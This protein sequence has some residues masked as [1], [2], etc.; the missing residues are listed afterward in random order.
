[1]KVSLN[2]LREYVEVPDDV[3]ALCELLTL[4]GVEVEGIETRGLTSDKV[5]VAEILSSEQHPNADR[6]SVCRVNDGGGEPRQIVCGAKNYR[7]GDKV[8]L[9]LPGAVLP[10]DFKIK[11]GKLRGVE[12]QGMMCSAKE[13]NL[14][15][16]A[17]G[18]LILP[19]SATVGTPVHELFAPDTVLDVEVTPNRPDLLSHVGMAREISALARR[20]LTVPTIDA[21]AGEANGGIEIRLRAGEDCPHY[22]A[23]RISG[24]QVKP[25]PEWMQRRLEAVGLRP[26]NNV[27]DVTNF[28]MLELGQPLHAF[29]AREI[30]RSIRVRHAT[31]G[32]N[33]LALDGRN[34]ALSPGHMVI[35]DDEKAL[36]IAGIMGGEHSG[37]TEKTTDVVLESAYFRP[38]N[39][40]R[41]SRELGLSSDSSYRFERGV[42]PAGVTAASLRAAKLIVE[43]GGGRIESFSEGGNAPADAVGVVALREGRCSE[44]AGT[45]IAEREVEAILSRL[46][47]TREGTGWRTPTYRPDLTREIDLVEEVV[48]VYGIENI[49]PRT[50][51]DFVSATRVDAIHD[52]LMEL[53]REL[54]A[55]GFFEARNVSMISA[56]ATTDDPLAVDSLRPIKNPL[57]EDQTHLRPNLLPGLLQA[58][59]HNLRSG[60]KSVRLFEIGRVFRAET[61][62]E[63]L[64]LATVMTGL[65]QPTSWRGGERSDV[66]F[67]D[68]KGVLASLRLADLRFA[69]ATLRGLPLAAEVRSGE[70]SLG[71]AGQLAPARARALDATA[72]VIV[73]E[74]DLSLLPLEARTTAVCREIGKFPGTSRDIATLAPLGVSHE[75]IETVLKDACEPLLRDVELFDL[76]VDPTGEKIPADRKSLAYSL[77]Y[78][79]DERTLTSDEVSA[80][81]A[82]LKERLKAAVDVQFRE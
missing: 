10:G 59:A 60:T 15:E 43:L 7:V 75:Q 17:E 79:S 11:A 72:A 8:P 38:Q 2:W 1:M 53:R 6:L 46:G 73:A 70:V 25:S 35:A 5:V 33:F 16:D 44:V 39:I 3:A 48:R 82:R 77:T 21:V 61:R 68:L 4:A 41:S 12:S 47:L 20:E 36:A 42:D 54:A 78:R 13:L 27:V 52:R 74:I 37:V 18:L 22:T 62:E 31:E 67:F 45:D 55:T 58:L 65:L 40:R 26:I 30:S 66:D 81:H 64:H 28:V 19:P 63:R 34:Y 49:P 56:E 14:A 32:E 50:R 29:D 80:A 24:V 76:F 51:G 71:F 9:A 57:S 69:P 23:R